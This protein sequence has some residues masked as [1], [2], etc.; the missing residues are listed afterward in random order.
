V[1]TLKKGLKEL[2][3]FLRRPLILDG[4]MGT[5]LNERGLTTDP[6]LW[7]S[8]SNLSDPASVIRLHLDYIAAGADI[9]TTNTFRTNPNALKL[10]GTSLSPEEFVLKSVRLALEAAGEKDLIIAG[11]NAPA[12]D[13]YQIERTLLPE[14]LEYNHKKHIQLLW[15]SGCDIIWN[16]TLSHWDEI[17]IICEYCSS[18]SLPFV[19]NLFFNDELQILS[20]E[21]VSEV[22]N[23]ISEYSPTAIGLNCIKPSAFVN[24]LEHIPLH[25]NWGVY[26]NCGSGD[27]TDP[28]I[29]CGLDP[30]SYA[31]LISPLLPHRP[32]YI[33][34][35][36]GSSP[37]HTSALKGLFN[38]I[39]RD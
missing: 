37:E 29:T 25:R 20:G 34:S 4:A 23:F 33:G 3:S 16:E 18:N 2:S 15:E 22:I 30:L 8:I 28:V 14:D 12:E 24:Y 11:S 7:S 5:V 35:C 31:R 26:L 10:S 32:L 27:V 17:K 6:L 21:P 39:Y 36:C 38:E 1:K 19:V 9:I 13:C